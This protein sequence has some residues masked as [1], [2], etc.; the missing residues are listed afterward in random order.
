MSELRARIIAYLLEHRVCILSTGG[1]VGAW[2]MPAW[3]RPL[4][5]TVGSQRLEVECLLPRWADVLY[6]LEHDPRVLLLIPDPE[7]SGLRWLQYQGA[8]RPIKSP[9]WNRLLPEGTS[10][11]RP[12]ERYVA[13]GVTPERID[14]IDESLGWGARET[15]DL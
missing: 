3:Y 12:E 10:R 11:V 1:S 6:H 13:V 9:D 8:A 15:L 5:G 14:L 4:A 7:S 2:A